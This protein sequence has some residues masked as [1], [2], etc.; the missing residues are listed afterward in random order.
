MVVSRDAEC[1]L[2]G[3]SWEAGFSRAISSST[4]V[5]LVLSRNAFDSIKDLTPSSPCDNVVL[6]HE[7]ALNLVLSVAS[8]MFPR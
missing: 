8:P 5:V 1:L 6:E 7:L 2:S 3:E 4:I